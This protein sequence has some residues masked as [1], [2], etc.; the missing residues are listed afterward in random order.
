M[1]L[2]KEFDFDDIS[3]FITINYN[4]INNK[5]K[6]SGNMEAEAVFLGIWVVFGHW[7]A[8]ESQ[9]R[10]FVKLGFENGYMFSNLWSSGRTL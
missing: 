10:I 3:K 7:M 5:R 9:Q 8:C 6:Y 2:I 1:V 4:R